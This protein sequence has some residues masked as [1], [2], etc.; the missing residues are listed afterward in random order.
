MLRSA[1]ALSPGSQP[2]DVVADFGIR[3]GVIAQIGDLSGSARKRT[4]LANRTDSNEETMFQR[5][6][7]RIMVNRILEILI[8]IS[9]L[10]LRILNRRRKSPEDIR[11]VNCNRPFSLGLA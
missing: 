10:T 4:I 7:Y 8:Q 11:G 3:G 2:F 9:P 6:K 5:V 1:V